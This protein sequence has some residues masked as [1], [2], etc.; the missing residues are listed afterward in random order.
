MAGTMRNFRC[1]IFVQLLAL[2]VA[3]P[4][5][6][7]QLTLKSFD[8]QVVVHPD[9]TIEVTEILEVKFE[10]SWN[11]I[12][13]TIPVEYRGSLGLNYTLFI[14]PEGVTDQ[15]GHP[16]KYE[17]SRQG[18]YKRFKIYVPGA[19]NTTKTIV[20][21]YEVLDGLRFF[22]D[23]DELYWN[24]TGNEW[25]MA[26]ENATARIELPAGVTGL[27]AE[28]FTGGYGQR[29]QEAEV[30]VEGNVVQIRMQ[31][32]LAFH[33][34]LTA[35]VGW[36]KGFVHPPS[37]IAKA[38]LF[39]R[40]NWPL[41]LPILAFFIMGWLWYSKGRDP[42]RNP[43][44]VQYEPP[45]GMS[46]GE[47]GTLVDNEVAMRDITATIVDLA[48]RG[49][50]TIEQTDSSQM[51]GL[52]HHKNYVFHRTKAATE[53]ANLKPH[54]QVMLAALFD[55]GA[56]D[57]VSLTDLQN[58]FYVHLP[59]IRNRIF[60]GLMSDGFYLHRPDKL[61]Q[62]FVGAGVAIG[63]VMVWGA[64]FL[65]STMGIS[66]VT[67]I[68]SGVLTGLI[69]AGFGY[70]MSARTVP[71]ERALEKVLGFEDFLGRVEKDQ[72]E[73]IEKTPEMFEKYLPY[74]MA[75]RVEKKW[76]GAFQD[77]CKQPPAW[78]SGPYGS[79]FA[80]YLFVTDLN[81]MSMQAGSAM[82]SSPR[83]A[84]GAGGSGFGGGGFS[85]GGFGGGGGGGF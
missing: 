24:V 9:S 35:V 50:L 17:M 32:P 73:R 45:E 2:A 30:K 41:F 64:G 6:A 8:E 18:Q 5:Q 26:I 42:R 84:G 55:G 82:A 14:E 28:A 80:P 59:A 33:E 40:S 12:Y 69:I 22:P 16:L 34:G 29:G 25:D 78:Y 13:R 60:D 4:A 62:G 15:D 43:I 76:A 66:A 27:H 23:H 56:S 71:G 67:T 74:A 48:V 49:F 3:L 83:S 81:L 54:E 44:S 75:L 37:V 72:I 1:V 70:F 51:L 53:W 21:R 39:L 63:F 52:V 19:D 10:G 20:I 58:H 57:S 47:A 65:S 61:R 46:P 38:I 68:A 85:G 36:D 11:G 79:G 31:R 77:I 7:R